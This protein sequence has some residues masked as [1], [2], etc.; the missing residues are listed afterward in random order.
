MLKPPTRRT[1]AANGWRM[2][3]D[4]ET[5]RCGTITAREILSRATND[6]CR[7]FAAESGGVRR[8]DTVA[9]NSWRG[10]KIT[11]SAKICLTCWRGGAK[12][13]ETAS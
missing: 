3:I 4:N 9:A 2:I 8:A 7:F 1:L 5:K 12:I 6:G 13:T 11:L 10:R